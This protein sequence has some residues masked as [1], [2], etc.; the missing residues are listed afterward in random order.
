MSRELFARCPEAA[1]LTP[2][3]IT[4][5]Q[6]TATVTQTITL[7]LNRPRRVLVIA[8][9]GTIHR[10]ATVM[11]TADELLAT[12]ADNTDGGSGPSVHPGAP[13]AVAFDA[14]FAGLTVHYQ[15]T[16]TV[17]GEVCAVMV[18]PEAMQ[19]AVLR[20]RRRVLARVAELLHAWH[21]ATRR[22][23][24]PRFARLLAT[25]R[26]GTVTQAGFAARLARLIPAAQ[27]PGFAPV[28]DA[29]TTAWQDL[30]AAERRF[31]VPLKL[32]QNVTLQSLDASVHMVASPAIDRGR[33][34]SARYRDELFA[35]W[36]ATAARLAE[37]RR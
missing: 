20:N 33:L 25:L 22:T 8:D 16:I 35:H 3:L 2:R 12:D 36:Q 24:W 29:L 14:A 30:Q 4:P 32:M 17:R 28:E 34:G 5:A 6:L 19:A 10:L 1:A 15:D 31:A 11:A 21:R 26:H 23:D 7:T 13:V 27:A 9:D 37:V 18:C